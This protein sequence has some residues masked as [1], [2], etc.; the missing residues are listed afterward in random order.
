MNDPACLHRNFYTY[1]SFVTAAN[2]F[3]GFG[4]SSDSA[5]VN[6]QEIAAFM[7]QISHETTGKSFHG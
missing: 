2:A 7:G 1:A 5:A 6:K 3:A 4:T